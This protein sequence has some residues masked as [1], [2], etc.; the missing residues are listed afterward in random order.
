MFRVQRPEFL[1]FGKE[2]EKYAPNLSNLAERFNQVSRWVVTC[3][4]I[5]KDTKE[6]ILLVE[7]F[8]KIAKRLYE[9]NNYNSLM[10]IMSGLNNIAIQRLKQIREGLHADTVEILEKLEEFISPKHNFKNYRSAEKPP[11]HLPYLALTLRDLT[12][13][14]DGNTDYLPNPLESDS[15]QLI[16]FEKLKMYSD[17]IYSVALSDITEE[18]QVAYA[19]IYQL[20]P[21]L[22]A[23]LQNLTFYDE[24]TLYEYSLKHS[25]LYHAINIPPLSTTSIPINAP[26]QNP[27][28]P[29]ENIYANMTTWNNPIY[30]A[31]LPPS[32]TRRRKKKNSS[33]IRNM[34]ASPTL[35]SEISMSLSNFGSIFKSYEK[36]HPCFLHCIYSTD[37]G[38][39][40]AVSIAG[41]AFRQCLKRSPYRNRQCS[42]L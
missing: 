16:N 26:T 40:F 24:D 22:R 25:E 18:G 3:I 1:Y 41:S 21:Q 7:K 27:P 11:L 29:S 36:Y 42:L 14:N 4:M 33:K 10:Q 35:Q 6:Q 20:H 17:I 9:M 31:T 13:I 19:K 39:I 37:F 12:F 2:K 38:H 28:S 23:F 30:M 34:Q 15:T 8:I 5:A 32:F